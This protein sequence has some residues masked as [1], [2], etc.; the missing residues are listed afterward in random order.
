MTR[1]K[2]DIRTYGASVSSPDNAPYIQA[3]IDAASTSGGVVYIPDGIY[4]TSE[5]YINAKYGLTITG[6]KQPSDGGTIGSILQ[7][8]GINKCIIFKYSSLITNSSGITTLQAGIAYGDM[9]NNT[10]LLFNTHKGWGEDMVSLE[11]CHVDII[12]R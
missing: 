5:L 3:A 8:T 9:C 6:D 12:P 10:P 2:H 1:T 7:Y 4:R 11:S